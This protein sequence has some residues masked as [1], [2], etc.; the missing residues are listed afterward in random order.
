[1]RVFVSADMEGITGVAAAEDVVRGEPE[2]ERGKELLHGDVNAAVEGAFAGGATDVL[3]NDSHSSMRNLDREAVDDRATL[4]RGNTKPRSMMQ[5]VADRDC[6]LFVGYHAKAGT[7]EA[8]LNHT[9]FGQAL[10]RLRVGDDEVGELGWNAR[11]AAAEGVPVGL[12]TG[13]DATV[14]EARDELGDAPETVAVKEGIDR[15]TAACRPASETTEEIRSAAR[16]AVERAADGDVEVP[17][18]ESPTR[19]EADWATT[20]PAAR[21]AGSPNVERAG[22]R[23]TAVE[24]ASYPETYEAT[25]AMLR[26]GGAGRDE[27]YG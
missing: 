17:D 24:A 3:V 22:G 25:V 23:T 14:A 4:V 12:V 15:F 5:G 20:N 27:F 2:Y 19:I 21:A 16:R 6:A 26:A 8:V 9:F 11:L 1:M 7:P 18:V 13:D 10:L